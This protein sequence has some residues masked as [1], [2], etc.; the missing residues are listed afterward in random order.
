MAS[1]LLTGKKLNDALSQ[2]EGADPL[3]DQE[4]I[5]L[6]NRVIMQ[7]ISAKGLQGDEVVHVYIQTREEL[8]ESMP[9]I[10]TTDT[11][12]SPATKLR[13]RTKRLIAKHVHALNPPAPTED[14]VER[15]ILDGYM[16]NYSAFVG[17][18]DESLVAAL[19]KVLKTLTYR[20]R[21]ILSLRYGL[22]NGYSFSAVE[23]AQIFKITKE[24]VRL[25]EAKAVGKLRR[26]PRVGYLKSAMLHQ[27]SEFDEIMEDMVPDEPQEQI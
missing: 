23:V 12:H 17:A 6:I 22:G 14:T 24:R 4:T 2:L 3:M 16:D 27:R 7:E 20:E 25:I 5:D 1:K 21:E 9:T 15:E 11:E 19:R 13:I 10:L 26:S 8:A 18:E